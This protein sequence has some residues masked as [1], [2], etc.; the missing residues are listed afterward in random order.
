M[1]TGRQFKEDEDQSILQGGNSIHKCGLLLTK[2][3]SLELLTMW[4]STEQAWNWCRSKR[5]QQEQW[6]INSIQVNKA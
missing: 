6:A 2:F 4:T 1:K 5:W 3:Q